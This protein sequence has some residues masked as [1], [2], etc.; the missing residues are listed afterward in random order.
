MECTSEGRDENGK[1]DVC[2]PPS[3]GLESE[4]AG[5]RSLWLASRLKPWLRTTD[6]LAMAYRCKPASKFH[7]WLD[8]DAVWG[9][10]WGRSVDEC[11][12]WG[13]RVVPL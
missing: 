11:I 12:R 4:T 2:R 9:G 6:G 5:L 7:G 10:E 3:R 1:M 8:P 13:P